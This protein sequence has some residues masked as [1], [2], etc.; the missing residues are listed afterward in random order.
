MKQG[1]RVRCRRRQFIFSHNNRRKK[2]PRLWCWGWHFVSFY[3]QSFNCFLD[4]F[5]LYLSSFFFSRS[6]CCLKSS[7]KRCF[8]WETT[9]WTVCRAWVRVKESTTRALQVTQTHCQG[10][11]NQM[12]ERKWSRVC[13]M[14]ST[15]TWHS[16]RTMFLQDFCSDFIQVNSWDKL[17]FFQKSKASCCDKYTQKQVPC[18]VTC[19]LSSSVSLLSKLMRKRTTRH[20]FMFFGCQVVVFT[21]FI[22]LRHILLE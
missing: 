12:R 16:R 3:H 13:L 11:S 18:L 21:L 10:V 6:N 14:Q 22:P 4:S 20:L 9:A 5:P 1:L 7:N 2:T 15:W 8:L 19:H 17:S